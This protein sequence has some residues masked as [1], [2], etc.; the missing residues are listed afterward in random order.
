[1]GK[2]LGLLAFDPQNVATLKN[3]RTSHCAGCIGG[4]SDLLIDVLPE[5][6]KRGLWKNRHRLR[7]EHVQAQ[8]PQLC[9]VMSN[10]DR[11]ASAVTVVASALVEIC[12]RYRDFAVTRRGCRRRR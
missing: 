3:L 2:D 8:P 5:E 9:I 1:M 11:K 12:H 7:T 10:C 4:E 6:R